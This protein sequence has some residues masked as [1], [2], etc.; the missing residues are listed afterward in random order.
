MKRRRAKTRQLVESL[1]AGESD[2]HA[3]ADKQGLSLI[4]MA[5][6]VERPR[7]A[8][9]LRLLENLQNRRMSLLLAAARADAAES[10]RRMAT[11]ESPRETARKACVDLLK[12][13]RDRE[14]GWGVAAG[15]GADTDQLHDPYAQINSV[16][17]GLSSGVH[18][19]HAPDLASADLHQPLTAPASTQGETTRGQA[20]QLSIKAQRRQ[21]AG[22]QG[23][24][25]DSTHAGPAEVDPP[26]HTSGAA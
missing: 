25:S 7:H 14:P 17:A 15:D 16:V 5:R 6:W 13:Q 18:G 22:E 2:L 8:E 23:P 26:G 20:T 1:A 10:L 11:A 24:E 3:L 21:A 19:A 4:D 9:L 12:L